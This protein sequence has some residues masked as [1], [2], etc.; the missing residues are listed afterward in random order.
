MTIFRNDPPGYVCPQ[1]GRVAVLVG[2]YANSNLN[3][4][5]PAYLFSSSAQEKDS[6]CWRAIEKV[7]P[8][9]DGQRF[10]VLFLSG[11]WTTVG[12]YKTIFVSP[13]HAAELSGNPTMKG[14]E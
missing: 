6:E 5:V 10:D 7:E 8:R 3:G 2:G 1:T 9:A 13:S 11:S 12:P 14:S 4:R